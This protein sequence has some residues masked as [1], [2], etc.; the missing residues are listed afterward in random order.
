MF[1]ALHGFFVPT[2]KTV[3]RKKE[4]KRTIK[5]TIKDSQEAFLFLGKCLQEVRSFEPSKNKKAKHTAVH[6]L[7]WR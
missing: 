4:G 1:W 3:I 7:H 5:Y 6:I 2:D